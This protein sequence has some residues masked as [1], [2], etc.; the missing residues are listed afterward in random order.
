MLRHEVLLPPVDGVHRR[1][2]ALDKVVSSCGDT[3]TWT[4][5]G[6]GLATAVTDSL[7]QSIVITYCTAPGQQDRIQSISGNGQTVSYARDACGNLA[8]VTLVAG[9]TQQTT[10]YVYGNGSSARNLVCVVAPADYDEMRQNGVMTT[11]G[12]L[13]AEDPTNGSTVGDPIGVSWNTYATTQYTYDG[14][15]RVASITDANGGV[16]TFS[17]SDWTN[18][19]LPPGLRN[20]NLISNVV[21]VTDN[22]G[23]ATMTA[24]DGLGWERFYDTWTT[25]N[26]AYHEAFTKTYDSYGRLTDVTYCDDSRASYHYVYFT[27]WDGAAG[28]S[29]DATT[30]PAWQVVQYKDQGTGLTVYRVL[31]HYTYGV[32]G[33]PSLPKTKTTY[34]DGTTDQVNNPNE[35]VTT[36]TANFVYNADGTLHYAVQ[37]LVNG[38]LPGQP[39]P[40][41][42]RLGVEY[43]YSSAFPGQVE[44]ATQFI[45]DSFTDCDSASR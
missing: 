36:F 29:G 44:S 14:S 31:A 32:P 5:D 41:D 27:Q 22:D 30:Y 20:A 40:K 42:Y 4:R 8:R 28:G 9:S 11:Q 39:A 38:L 6:S 7:G 1:G 25:A 16:R 35:G 19:R 33:F 23:L 26:P 2:H 21:T 24:V 10:L 17:Y 43:T 18:P 12:P 45:C 15:N 3:A 13:S 34:V 37:P